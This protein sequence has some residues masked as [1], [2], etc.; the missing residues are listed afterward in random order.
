MQ[1]E[2]IMAPMGKAENGFFAQDT[3]KIV[4]DDRINKTEDETKISRAVKAESAGYD[5]NTLKGAGSFEEVA[6]SI[7]AESDKA[8]L[9]KVAKTLGA[10]DYDKLDEDDYSPEAMEERRINTV[11]EKIQMEMAKAGLDI[12]KLAGNLDASDIEAITGSSAAAKDIEAALAKVSEISVSGNS[13][14]DGEL[15]YLLSNELSPTIDNVYAAKFSG[16]TMPSQPV[17]ASNG[18]YESIKESA[19]KIIREA[20]L[21]V[22]EKTTAEA[23][24]IFDQGLPL[25]AENIQILDTLKN[26]NLTTDAE[27]VASAIAVSVA[28]GKTP[29]AAY[30]V[31]GFSTIERAIDAKNVIDNATVEQIEAIEETGAEVT[32]NTLKAEQ[33]KSNSA[34]S[35]QGNKNAQPKSSDIESITSYRKLEEIRLTMTI[36]ANFSL[37]KR[38]VSIETEPLTKLVDN[39]KNIENEFYSKLLNIDEKDVSS[40]IIETFENATK[41]IA[42]LKQAPAYVI[43]QIN[44]KS[45]TLVE[46]RN[47]VWD[48]KDRFDKANE[49]YEALGTSPRADLGDSMKK[50]FGNI[51]SILDDIGLDANSAN[52]RAVRILGYNH[53]EI[54]VE[55]VLSVRDADE[56]CQQ[57]FKA[58]TPSVV[59][60]MV[61]SGVNPLDMTMEELV[62]KAQE[63]KT[64]NNI[65]NDSERFSKFLVKLE[66][67]KEISAEER[68]AYI[69]IYRL[70]KRVEATDGAAIGSLLNQEREITMR[71]LM[72][73]VRTSKKKGIDEVASDDKGA[74]EVSRKELTITQQI[75]QNIAVNQIHALADTITPAILSSMDEDPMDMPLEKFL[76]KTE[77]PVNKEIVEEETKEY[78]KAQI[79]EMREASEASDDI[80][81]ALKNMGIATTT[82]NIAAITYMMQNKNSFF[83]KVFSQAQKN[84]TPDIDALIEKCILEFGEDAKTPK[85]M[86]EAEEALAELAEHAMDGYITEEEVSNIDIRGMKLTR[87]VVH[88]IKEMAKQDTFHLPIKVNDSTGNVSLKIVE[89]SNESG[90]MK[91]IFSS[92]ETGEISGE[93]RLTPDAL[94]GKLEAEDSETTR[95]LE[96]NIGALTEVL[97][98]EFSVETYISLDYEGLSQ[99]D[100]Y[101]AEEG[102]SENE[103]DAVVSTR[104]LYNLT[105]RVL[106]FLKNI[107]EAV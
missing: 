8:K 89:G 33:T 53:M 59:T 77:N 101:Q 75:E 29:G 64:E 17:A 50:A 35:Q 84:A 4:T 96:E 82:E 25:T 27:S 54:T 52:Q 103:G 43:G 23:K 98:R 2:N 22:N 102:Q 32:V 76:E 12:S 13:L 79:N 97:S 107:A 6:N 93:F 67:N 14:S 55:S 90:L 81:S 85:E 95:M 45:A 91:L 7:S 69:G 15:K 36:Q 41:A 46:I 63:I 87:P 99:L 61:K 73:A 105:G 44:I 62:A 68:E 92:I 28:E 18:A 20:G 65:D 10:D 80:Y 30:L 60:E 71:N 70:I 16:A 11:V 39:L 72:T 49:T 106:S 34:N 5:K 56:T 24:W 88:A 51:D 1:I 100:L 19:E 40:S 21:P 26:N 104:S 74:T 57:A 3:P 66:Q 42:D 38:G 94:S 58:L 37:I 48:L 31:P 47:V 86:A 9:E 78:A 83:R